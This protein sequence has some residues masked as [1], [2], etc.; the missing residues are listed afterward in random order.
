MIDWGA[1][2]LCACVGVIVLLTGVGWTATDW[3][4]SGS[5]FSQTT[6]DQKRADLL[7]HFGA[8]SNNNNN[9]WPRLVPL[10]EI[11]FHSVNLSGP[12]S[13][14]S[15]PGEATCPAKLQLFSRVRPI[16]DAI[17]RIMC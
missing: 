1:R 6:S 14:L 2:K 13:L 16:T 4:A 5:K 3:T 17:E 8:K 9:N 11:S 12:T 15:R 10:N 7:P